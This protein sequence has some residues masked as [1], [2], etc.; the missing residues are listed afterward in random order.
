ML[1]S[2]IFRRLVIL[3]FSLIA[4]CLSVFAL[5]MLDTFNQ[6]TMENINSSVV[7]ATRNIQFALVQPNH[8]PSMLNSPRIGNYLDEIAKVNNVD[9]YIFDEHKKLVASS[10][11]AQNNLPML[12]T[13]D[14]HQL[15][16]TKVRTFTRKNLQTD[17]NL[18]LA[19]TL[20]PFNNSNYILLTSGNIQSMSQNYVYIQKI[21]FASL[22][23]AYIIAFLL[24]LH[25]ARRFVKPIEKLTVA[26]QNFAAGKLDQRTHLNTNDEFAVLGYALNNLAGTLANKISE[27]DMEKRKLELILEQM[28]DAVMLL[29]QQGRVQTIN[30][31]ALNIFCAEQAS[32]SL[33]HNLDILGSAHFETAFRESLTQNSSRT[34][35]L[36]IKNNELNKV[37]RTYLTPITVAYSTTPKYVLCVMH[38]ITA[39]MQVYDKQVEFVANASH[40]LSTPLTSIRGFAE[41]LEDVADNPKL[42]AKFSRIIQDEALRMQ[43]LITDLLKL[44][45]LDSL[46]YSR[47]IPL[48]MVSTNGLLEEI[49]T[50]LCSQAQGKNIKLNCENNLAVQ[51]IYSNRDW[52]KQALINLTENAIKYTPAGGRVQ[53]RSYSENGQIKFAVQDSGK[54][55]SEADLKKI[56]DRFYRVDS[57]R[58]RSTGGTGLGLSIVRFIVQI[59]DAKIDVRS[60]QEIGTTFTISIPAK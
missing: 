26:A 59:L 21:T 2:K 1:N 51:D 10:T 42:V 54:G 3:F 57:D 52:L 8:Q 20:L 19:A 38:D 25:A 48:S 47:A 13:L 22:A 33:L 16:L 23:V 36:K 15:D 39:I 7:Q 14:T 56:F 6:N 35:D 46:E 34:V 11:N 32:T 41:T 31:Y 24:C 12:D 9:I 50:E 29:D 58:N 45:K 17:Q 18:L 37:F 27:M 4:S 53:L 60:E 30:K 55:M 49:C 28:D 44:A 5:Y 43:R 40:E